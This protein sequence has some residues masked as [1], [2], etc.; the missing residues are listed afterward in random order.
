MYIIRDFKVVV[1]MT[2]GAKVTL[3]KKRGRRV[4]MQVQNAVEAEK[5]KLFMKGLIQKVEKFKT[6][7]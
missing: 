6:M 5:E 2:K 7:Y 4:Q 1:G 3:L